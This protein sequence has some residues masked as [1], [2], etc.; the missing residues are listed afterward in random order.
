MDGIRPIRRSGARSPIWY[1]FPPAAAFLVVLLLF[2]ICGLYP[3]GEKTLAWCDMRQQVAPLLLD[4]K[5][6]LKGEDSILLNLSNAGGMSLWGVFFFFLS[7]PFSFLVWFVDTADIFLFMNLL[8]LMKVPV[9]AFTAGIFLYQRRPGLNPAEITALSVAYALSG[10]TMLYFQ[11]IVWLDMVYLFPVLLLGFFRLA[12]KK[13]PGLFLVSLCAVVIVHFYLS[14]MVVLF[15]ILA[16][17]M[18]LFWGISPQDRDRKLLLFAGCAV[19]AALLTAVVWLPSLMQ[20]LRSARTTGLL[21]SLSSGNFFTRYSTT[22]ATFTNAVSVFASLPI[23]FLFQRGALSERRTQWQFS[24][25]LFLLLPIVIEPINK[26]WH[27]GSY[28]AFPTRYGY[29]SVFLGMM[30]LSSVMERSAGLQ[31]WNLPPH[32]SRILPAA[33]GI[34]LVLLAWSGLILISRHYEELT[35]YTRRL[36]NSTGGFWLM[37]G[38]AGIA[39]AFYFLLFFGLHTRQIARGVFSL[40]LCIGILCEVLFSGFIYFGAPAFEDTGYRYVLDLAGR[41]EDDT[42]YRVKNEKKY[43]D[44]NL[45]GGLGY[46]TLNH[47]TS[48][49]SED[50]LY[51]MKKLGYSSYWME[52]NSSGG[53]SLTDWLLANRY[54]I[55]SENDRQ[56]EGDPIYANDRASILESGLETALG[57]I[58]HTEDISTL[59]NLPDLSRAELQ[60]FLFQSLF[61]GESGLIIPYDW[62]VA[63]DIAYSEGENYTLERLSSSSGFLYYEMDITGTQTLYFD[64]FDKVTSNLSEPINSS[65]HIYVNGRTVESYYPSQRSNGLVKLGTFSDEHVTITIEVRKDIIAKSFGVFGLDEDKLRTA[66]GHSGQADFTREGNTLRASAEAD[67]G[68][69]WML[70]SLPYDSGYTATVNGQKAELVPVLDDLMAVKLE[71][72]ENEITIS[73]LPTGLIAGFCL[74]VLGAAALVFAILL[75]RR[76]WIPSGRRWGRVL[77][78]GFRLLFC[79]VILAVYIVPVFIYLF[80]SQI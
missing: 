49:I 67:D 61:P 79:D 41:I 63:E 30:L 53:T 11:N 31:T 52:V 77:N 12:E 78:L 20:Y 38:F 37:L 70:V 35:A 17:G 47:Y 62:R 9:C 36:W 14:Y 54:V 21:E 45:L 23:L 15:L 2:G 22:Y 26:M 74:S 42:V 69:A 71:Q 7:S 50:Y 33:L 10:Y 55:L 13:K 64:C 51:M 65:V 18:Y 16:L 58:I 32:R 59:Q 29:I 48:L 39:A 43:F 40:F 66:V 27:T 57:K 5:N 72:G 76:G 60:E 68:D 24:M 75:R 80:R 28:Q 73:Y 44:V 46:S 56:G 8:V 34:I 19:L 3:L 25:F 1:L 6:I 4:L